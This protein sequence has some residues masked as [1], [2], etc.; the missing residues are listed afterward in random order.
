MNS[1]FFWRTK[2]LSRK[3]LTAVIS[4]KGEEIIYFKG[5]NLNVYPGQGAD[6]REFMN[7]IY[8]IRREI[9]AENISNALI[10]DVGL[11]YKEIE[12]F[13]SYFNEAKT[14]TT[15]G[16]SE[17]TKQLDDLAAKLQTKG[18]EDLARKARQVADKIR[19]ELR[20][21]DPKY[22][23]P[24]P[25]INLT[26]LQDIKEVFKRVGGR[27]KSIM[28]G[29][30]SRLPLI[31]AIIAIVA[32]VFSIIFAVVKLAKRGTVAA[33]KGVHGIGKGIAKFLAK[34]G[35]IMASIG[36]FIIS[37]MSF[38]AQ[39]IMWVAN[40]LWILLVAQNKQMIRYFRQMNREVEEERT[41]LVMMIIIALTRKGAGLNINIFGVIVDWYLKMG[42]LRK[43]SRDIVSE[44]T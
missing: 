5:K 27:L 28:E 31:G 19:T 8:D 2:F 18:R 38:L 39:G 40:N 29:L 34:F 30:R 17:K 32:G 3:S 36:S 15:E 23:E 7:I 35:P 44:I 10:V 20:A 24:E 12:K 26:F 21:E 16:Q 25:I 1:D 6:A 9:Q 41:L 4:Y 37:L 11:S 13:Y 14:L 33:A 22:D 42:T 43:A